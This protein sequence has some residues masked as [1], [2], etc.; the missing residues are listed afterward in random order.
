MDIL[1]G[2]LNKYRKIIKD[3]SNLKQIIS[4][5]LSEGGG[6][7]VDP[8][9]IKIRNQSIFIACSQTVK[10]EIFIKQNTLLK[11]INEKTKLK[12]KDIR[13]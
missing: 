12:F 5:T 6:L 10:S 7:F 1:S 9:F 2:F 8:K 11:I 13:F 3:D 4:D